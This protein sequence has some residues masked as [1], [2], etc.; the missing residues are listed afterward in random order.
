YRSGTRRVLNPSVRHEKNPLIKSDKPWETQ[1]AWNS[2]YRDPRSG[3]YQLWY[4]A[5]NVTAKERAKT[6]VVA[7]AESDDGV[8]FTKP[9]LDLFPFNDVAKTNIV[10]IGS[11]GHSYRYCNSVLV[12][13]RDPD[14]AKRYKMAYFD[15]GKNPGLFVAFSPDG[16]HWTKHSKEPLSRITYEGYE[17]PVP[18]ADEKEKRPWA[19]PLSMSDA[20]DVFFDPQRKVYAWYGKM[21][22]DGPAGAMAWKHAMGRSESKD[23]LHWSRPELV[24]APDDLDKPHVEFHTSPVFFHEGV[25]FSLNQ[26]LDRASGEGV[27]DV[28]L[29][30]SRDGLRWERNFRNEFFLPR[31]REKGAFDSGSVFTN[32]TPVILDDE[33]RFYFGGYAG[34][35]TGADNLT[36]ASGVGVATI[37]RDRFAGIRP[38][39]KSDQPTLKTP[40]ENVGQVT[41]KPIELSKEMKITI[42]ADARD[43]EI[44]VELLDEEMRRVRGFSREEASVITGDSLRHAVKW[45]EKTLAD[46]PPGQ[47]HLRAHLDHATLF[48]VSIAPASP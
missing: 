21:W 40:L 12:E 13:P 36:G 44:R 8:H 1:I 32:A 33:I 16:I 25:Y 17:S 46:L 11:G 19:T 39:E 34:G 2:V 38:V 9:P 28:E 42:N 6:C 27:I 37:P 35:A 20:V 26:I 15:W 47:Y 31:S 22:I 29:M 18:F 43:G 10:L 3:K 14:P 30:T 5:W 23:F 24:L 41:L 48:A 45:K 7:Y 4:Q